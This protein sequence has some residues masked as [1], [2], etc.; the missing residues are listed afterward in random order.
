MVKSQLQHFYAS[1]RKMCDANMTALKILPT[2]S[3]KEFDKVAN[4]RPQLWER[5]RKLAENLCLQG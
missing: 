1:H 2:I 5:F 3:M 4:M